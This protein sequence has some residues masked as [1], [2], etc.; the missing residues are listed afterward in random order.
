MIHFI[1]IDVFKFDILR[2]VDISSVAFGKFGFS[3]TSLNA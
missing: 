3:N 2:Y 1:K